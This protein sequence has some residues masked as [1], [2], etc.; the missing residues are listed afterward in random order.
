MVV[1]SEQELLK[2]QHEKELL[3]LKREKDE[4]VSKIG[5]EKQSQVEIIAEKLKAQCVEFE[6]TNA[7]MEELKVTY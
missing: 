7:E 5:K 2:H 3:D 1:K 6:K 4:E